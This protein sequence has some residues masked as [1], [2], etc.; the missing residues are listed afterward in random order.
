[1]IN[2]LTILLEIVISQNQV[3]A[4]SPPN[5]VEGFFLISTLNSIYI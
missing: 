3:T 2:F 1:M 4:D 5:K